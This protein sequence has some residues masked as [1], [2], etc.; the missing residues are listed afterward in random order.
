MVEE[1]KRILD[2]NRSEKIAAFERSAHI[3]EDVAERYG[4][5]VDL[6]GYVP[7]TEEEIEE[8]MHRDYLEK[9]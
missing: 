1:T 7:M 9:Q 5:M 3:I 8:A 2:E 6:S 4:L